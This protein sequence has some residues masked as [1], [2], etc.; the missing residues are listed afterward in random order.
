M[1]MSLSNSRFRLNFPQLSSTMGLPLGLLLRGG[2]PGLRSSTKKNSPL[3]RQIEVDHEDEVGA[4]EEEEDNVA[5]DDD[6]DE[7]D[8]EGKDKRE[9]MSVSA[10]ADGNR[11]SDK[12]VEDDEEE[13]E[14]EEGE[15]VLFEAPPPV[16]LSLC[17]LLITD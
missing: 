13:E 7:D 15:M 2:N 8:N 6:D 17:I 12:V 14:E 3:E 5:G 16:P 10:A 4:E 9:D 1:P 11:S